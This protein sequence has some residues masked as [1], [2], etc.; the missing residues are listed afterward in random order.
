MDN[1][2]KPIVGLLVVSN[3]ERHFSLFRELDGIAQQ[4]GQNLKP[5]VHIK[6]PARD[7][8]FAIAIQLDALLFGKQM[9][10]FGHP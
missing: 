4:V 7:V 1:R 2:D 8:Q 5:F 9:M 3:P 6:L 10:H